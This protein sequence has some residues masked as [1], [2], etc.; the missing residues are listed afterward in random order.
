MPYFRLFL[1]VLLFLGALVAF[2]IGKV[3]HPMNKARTIDVRR[4]GVLGVVAGALLLGLACVRIVPA[5]TVVF[6]TT[7][8]AIGAPMSPG[9]KLVTPSD[10][11]AMKVDLTIRFA[12][13]PEAASMLYRRVGDMD[14]IRDRIVRPE[15]REGVRVV[16]G[17]FTAE[18][19]YTAT[20]ATCPPRST[21]FGWRA[22]SISPRSQV[23]QITSPP[24]L[25]E[26]RSP[27]VQIRLVD[28]HEHYDLPF[29]VDNID[30]MKRA[31]PALQQSHALGTAHP[32]WT[33]RRRL[34]IRAGTPPWP[35]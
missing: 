31:S 3:R 15:T 4:F 25:S 22:S 33:P 20:T 18:E 35:R 1:G 27:M 26:P 8:G 21:T 23:T 5:N 28:R 29:V 17:N 11:Y 30:D 32:P 7:F 6:P 16:F 13:R 12:V 9:L 14:G 24:P 2:F 19:G 10:G 34:P